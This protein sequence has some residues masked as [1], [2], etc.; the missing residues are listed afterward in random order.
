MLFKVLL[1]LIFFASSLAFAT[2]TLISPA[3][4]GSAQEQ[5]LANFSQAA[6]Q[7]GSRTA[8]FTFFGVNGDLAFVRNTDPLNYIDIDLS[9]N[10]T[11]YL[12]PTAWASADNYRQLFLEPIDTA[13]LKAG[14][15]IFQ[16][17]FQWSSVL[18]GLARVDAIIRIT[19]ADGKILPQ[20]EYQ[21]TSESAHQPTFGMF[22]PPNFSDPIVGLQ[23][24]SLTH[25]QPRQNEQQID[26]IQPGTWTYFD[27]MTTLHRAVRPELEQYYQTFSYLNFTGN[28]ALSGD[29]NYDNFVYILNDHLFVAPTQLDHTDNVTTLQMSPTTSAFFMVQGGFRKNSVSGQTERIVSTIQIADPAGKILSTMPYSETSTPL[30]TP[31]SQ[32]VEDYLSPATPVY[33]I[34]DPHE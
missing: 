6:H 10:G 12:I 16:S 13:A 1:P 24:R 2:T 4:S 32:Y 19:G 27:T 15:Y 25:L 7:G 23:A 3:P 14:L 5:F 18:D 34:A 33:I 20:L 11:Y 22:F 26:E 30:S 29:L 17:G 21:V 8:T 28:A 9:L 31:T